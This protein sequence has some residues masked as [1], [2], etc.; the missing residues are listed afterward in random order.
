VVIP[1]V[2]LLF[3]SGPYYY[4][5]RVI[6][7]VAPTEARSCLALVLLAATLGRLLLLAAIVAPVLVLL[8]AVVLNPLTVDCLRGAGFLI[9]L[10][11]DISR[12]LTLD[13]CLKL[14]TGGSGRGLLP[15]DGAVM[16]L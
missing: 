8:E 15:L 1:N 2:L 7:T 3:L 14:V 6:A 4:V 5:R 13:A 9:G 11:P 12:L 16:V 10:E